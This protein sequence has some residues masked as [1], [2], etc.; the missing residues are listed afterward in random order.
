MRQL[1]DDFRFKIIPASPD[2]FELGLSLYEQ[3]PD[4]EWSLTDCISM[5][6]MRRE[7]IRHVLTTDHH[8]EQAGFEILLK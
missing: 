8:F 5:E 6:A 7:Q 3:R 2:D 1:C 4:K